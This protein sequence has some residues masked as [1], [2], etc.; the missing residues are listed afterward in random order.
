MFPFFGNL[1]VIR[2]IS[3][4][5]SAQNWTGLLQKYSTEEDI[6]NNPSFV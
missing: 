5:R 6:L 3:K 1:G 2:F 4:Q